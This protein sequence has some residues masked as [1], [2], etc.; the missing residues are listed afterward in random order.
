MTSNHGRP[1]SSAVRVLRFAIGV[2]VFLVLPSLAWSQQSDSSAA[3]AARIDRLIQQL[4]DDK[5]EVR[6]KAEAELAAIGEPALAK[7]TVAAKDAS[8]ERSQRAAK[9]K[10]EKSQILAIGNRVALDRTA[11]S[12]PFIKCRLS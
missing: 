4:D 10:E 1:R 2:F 5:F 6:E 12:P 7:L 9:E 11:M 8:A 3:L